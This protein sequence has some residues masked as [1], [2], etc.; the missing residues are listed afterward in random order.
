MSPPVIADEGH[1]HHVL[2]A[3][4][5]ETSQ[6]KVEILGTGE[7][8]PQAA[9]LLDEVAPNHRKVVREI[10]GDGHLR[11]PVAFELRVE[12]VPGVIDLVFV[13]IEV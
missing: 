11:A 1:V 4:H 3:K 13:G 9:D 7:V 12:A 8:G 5:L 10:V 2:I 6:E